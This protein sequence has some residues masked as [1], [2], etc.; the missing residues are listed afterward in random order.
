M[1]LSDSVRAIADATGQPFGRVNTVARRLQEI[2]AIPLGPGGRIAAD[3]DTYEVALI[4]L[5]LLINAPAHVA[6]KIAVEVAA[7]R[8]EEITAQDW[9]VDL[10]E[11]A[12]AIPV[13][14]T[15]HCAEHETALEIVSGDDS[16]FFTRDGQ[17]FEARSRGAVVA[18]FTLPAVPMQR[19]AE[20]LGKLS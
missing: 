2:D 18:S 6:A 13:S 16:W 8:W 5:A 1:R 3:V 15:A 7:Y 14:V 9:L 20:R 11:T 12:H 10:I 4:L 17:P 19:L